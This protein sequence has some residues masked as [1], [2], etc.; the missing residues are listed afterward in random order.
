MNQLLKSRA[1][2]VLIVFLAAGG[3]LIAFEHRAHIFTGNGI[4]I[5]LL[6]VCIGMHLF[7]HGGH[8][9][10]HGKNHGGNSDPE[11]NDDDRETK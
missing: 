8:G 11:R 4:L 7:M 6:A 5:G 2:L 1:G 9:H 3:F 10:G